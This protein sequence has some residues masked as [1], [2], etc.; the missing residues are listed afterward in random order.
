MFSSQSLSSLFL[1][2]SRER[3][4]YQPSSPQCPNLPAMC[5][6]PYNGWLVVGCDFTGSNTPD[7]IWDA[8]RHLQ[9]AFTMFSTVNHRSPPLPNTIK[10]PMTATCTRRQDPSKN[11]VVTIT[12]QPC[13]PNG[14]IS[15]SFSSQPSPP[16][17]PGPHHISIKLISGVG[18]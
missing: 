8:G 7:K 11:V 3:S 10:L 5:V 16:L 9:T 18:Q 6:K 4:I 13:F 1:T 15:R 17:P 14:L 12:T 2:L